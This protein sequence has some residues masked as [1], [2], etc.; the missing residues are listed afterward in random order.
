MQDQPWTSLIVRSEQDQSTSRLFYPNL[1]PEYAANAERQWNESRSGPWDSISGTT[2]PTHLFLSYTEEELRA[3]NATH[4]LST[5]RTTQSHL[6]IILFTHPCK[7]P[8]L[9]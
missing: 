8:D 9:T 7:A 6:E 5:N 3:A 2:G 1:Y 4:L